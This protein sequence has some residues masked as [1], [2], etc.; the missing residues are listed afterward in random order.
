[1]TNILFLYSDMHPDI[2]YRQ[3]M[4][5][6]LAPLYYALDYDSIPEEFDIDPLLKEFCARHWVAADAWMLFDVVMKGAGRWYEWQEGKSQ[7][8]P[9]PFPSH[10]QL[11]VSADTRLKPYIA[12]IVEACNR[13]QSVLLKGVDPELWKAMQT[14]GIEPQI[15]GMYVIPSRHF[16]A[17]SYSY[18]AGG[19]ACS[20]RES[21]TWKMP[22]FFGMVSSPLTRLS[23]WPNGSVSR[24]SYVYGTS[25]CIILRLSVRVTDGYVAVI[26]SDYSSQ[27]TYLLRY[28]ADPLAAG[29]TQEPHGVHHASLLLHQALTLQMSPTPTTGVSVIHENK[30]LLGIS[31]EVP[32]PV[33]PPVHRRPRH[34]SRSRSFTNTNG[35]LVPGEPGNSKGIHSRQTSSPMGLPE[36]LA[37]GLFE[38]GESLGINKTVMNAVSELK[39]RH[40]C[41]LSVPS[42]GALTLRDTEK[43]P[44]YIYRSCTVTSSDPSAGEHFVSYVAGQTSRRTSTVGTAHTARDGARYRADDRDATK[45]WG[46]SRVDRRHAL[47][48]RRRS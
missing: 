24:C 43:S 42:S 17:H 6:L 37:R 12:P 14:A 32:P 20:L 16:R 21:I 25:V 13:V 30:N 31:T 41:F 44:G 18:V 38:R 35:S 22:W 19:Y 11:N 29:S 10:V 8:D 15:Y 47:V 39:V 3:G 26:P 4:H 23:T 1:M 2:G 9:S 36:S 27:L 7:T 45:A 46:L 34:G 5:E 40:I 33:S 28:P 48:G